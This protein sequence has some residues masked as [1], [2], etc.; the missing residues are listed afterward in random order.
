MRDNSWKRKKLEIS[1]IVLAFG[2]ERGW[3]N[4]ERALLNEKK[5]DVAHLGNRVLRLEMAVVS[6]IA[7]T[8]DTMGSWGCGTDSFL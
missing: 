2:S 7:I 6:A 3:S 1:H 5:W 8:A 4:S